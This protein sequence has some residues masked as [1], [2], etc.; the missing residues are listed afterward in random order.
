MFP[1]QRAKASGSVKMIRKYSYKVVRGELIFNDDDMQKINEL[2][3][4][5][6]SAVL[7]YANMYAKI[8]KFINIQTKLPK[9]LNKTAKEY[10]KTLVKQNGRNAIFTNI[11]KTK[12]IRNNIEEKIEKSENIVSKEAIKHLKN[13]KVIG[14][15]NNFIKLERN[16]VRTN[17]EFK[18]VNITTLEYRK[19]VKAFYRCKRKQL[20]LEALE[21]LKIN[22][23][24]KGR[25]TIE[26]CDPIIK[27]KTIDIFL[28]FQ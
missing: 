19:I 24:P 18:T 28:Y 9:N 23:K 6:H 1:T 11:E 10:A 2:I 27:K 7:Q 13:K 12:E 20:L 14:I 4:E 5:W 17:D 3:M 15:N 21:S 25:K 8:G 16:Y 26:V 22:N